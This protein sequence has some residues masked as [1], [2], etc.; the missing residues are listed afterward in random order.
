MAS[1]PHT[2]LPAS[3]GSAPL[4]RWRVR[5][6]ERTGLMLGAALVAGLALAVTLPLHTGTALSP[7]VPS[8]RDYQATRALAYVS[9]VRTD[10]A[11][12]AAAAQVAPVYELDLT[13]AERQV[14]RVRAV[15]HHVDLLRALPGYAEPDDDKR[16]WLDDIPELQGLPP[17][18]VDVLLGLA[19]DGGLSGETLAAITDEAAEVVARVMR[20]RVSDANRPVLLDRL[21]ELVDPGMDGAQAQW[22]AD[23]AAR[24]VVLNTVENAARTRALRQAAREATAPVRV[25]YVR[26][27]TIARQGERLSAA[28]IEALTEAGL[29]PG[30]FS[31]RALAGHGLLFLALVGVLAA[32]L[33]RLR[34]GYWRRTRALTLM[35]AMLLAFTFAARFA[36]ASDEAL[37]APAFPAAAAAMTV[38]AVLGV[39]TGLFAAVLLA[40]AI[41]LIGGPHLETTCFVLLGGAA[42]A[43]ALARVERLKTFLYAAGVVA[44]VDLAVIYGFA[45]AG[46]ADD[47]VGWAELAGVAV[48][49][50]ALSSGL[51]ALGVLA[52]GSLFDV[53]TSFQLLELLRPDHP[54]LHELQIKAPGT[55]QHSIVLGNLAE[56]AAV[57]IG[58]DALLVRVGAYYHDI[59]KT[60]RPYFFV[61]NQLGVMNPH[62]GLDP[63]A[64]AR[65][66]IDHVTEGVALARQ[67]R[68]PAPVIRIIEQHHGTQRAEYFYHRAVHQSDRTAGVDPD[69]FAYPGPRPQSR[70]AAIVMLAD[71]VEA[72][73]RA[74]S[75]QSAAEIDALVHRLIQQR[76]ESGQLEDSDLTLGDL[77]RIRRAFVRTLRT[78]YHPR[79]QYPAGVAAAGGEAAASR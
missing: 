16:A 77:R 19:D 31:W 3:R 15:M 73:V 74:E 24:F 14:A 67:H 5:S 79:V 42:G 61:E 63:G 33:A 43:I 20:Q 45:L 2:E 57:A 60:A 27:E 1:A 8:P 78:M 54:L 17:A 76:V 49:H 58:A 11:R 48:A 55:Y 25:T 26:G 56:A 35:T 47:A 72:T 69:A 10:E 66:V 50:A 21:I 13:A 46:P 62:D 38:A 4:T 36:V 53:T 7:G 71:A 6:P 41:G 59:G 68:L 18:R 30:L 34:P 75:P 23:L 29:Q 32:G 52:A 44:V 70:E 51:A 28:Q 64:S 12:D 37:L 65:I 39:E 22:V 40:V 9:R